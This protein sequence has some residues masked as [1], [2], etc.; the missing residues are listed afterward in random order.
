MPIAN[1]ALTVHLL[2]RPAP[3]PLTPCGPSLH[4]SAK[5]SEL[6]S[7]SVAALDLDCIALQ[8]CPEAEAADL[9]RQLGGSWRLTE[10]AQPMKPPVKA[11]CLGH[12]PI[13][14]HHT[15]KIFH[16]RTKHLRKVPKLMIKHWEKPKAEKMYLKE[17]FFCHLTASRGKNIFRETYLC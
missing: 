3:C 17:V 16:T 5:G 6:L 13:S 2:R 9:V 11:L 10:G 15:T 4:F 1:I 7:G 8:E 12:T 14:L